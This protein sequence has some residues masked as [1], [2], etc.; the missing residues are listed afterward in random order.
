M[1]RLSFLLPALILAVQPLA[2]AQAQ[3]EGEGRLLYQFRVEH[4][5]RNVG[6]TEDQARSVAD[7]WARFDRELFEKTRQV[8]E[9]RT[10]FNDILM[11]PGTEDEKNARVKPLL[12]Q[13]V[14]LRHQQMNLKMQFEDDIRSRLSPAQQVR[15]IVQVDEMQRRMLEVLRQGLGNRPGMG[16]GNRMGP[17]AGLRR[18][19]R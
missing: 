6:L 10:Q 7:R 14:A 9:L 16:L 12:D 4:L 13:F 19:G 15:L 1:S 8:R 3:P 18:G 17:G 11:G 2:M 5:E